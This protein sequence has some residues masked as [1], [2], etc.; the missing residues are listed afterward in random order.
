[1]SNLGIVYYLN[2]D[3]SIDLFIKD[4]GEFVI[5]RLVVKMAE[6]V[7]NE[8]QS[9]DSNNYKLKQAIKISSYVELLNKGYSFEE[10]NN[11]LSNEFYKQYRYGKRVTTLFAIE[12]EQKALFLANKV[13]KKDSETEELQSIL[14]YINEVMSICNKK[15]NKGMCLRRELNRVC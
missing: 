13:Y 4:N 6:S 14:T 15:I 7:I 3:N 8:Y 2:Q 5:S 9:N 10:I 1:M 11:L 12:E